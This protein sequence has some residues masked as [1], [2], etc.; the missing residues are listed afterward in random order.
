MHLNPARPE[1]RLVP[2]AATANGTLPT[3]HVLDVSSSWSRRGGMHRV[4]MARHERLRALGWRHTLMAPGAAGPGLIDCGGLSVPG[5]QGRLVLSRARASRQMSFI[6]PDLIEATDPDLLG[7]AALAAAR[8]LQV[9]AVAFCHRD[10][11]GLAAQRLGSRGAQRWARRYLVSLYER[12]DLVMAPSRH[13]VQ[14]LHAWG[15]PHA[16][17]QPL[18][19]DCS[20]FTPCARDAAWR[21]QFCREQGLAPDTRLIVCTGRFTAHKNLQMLADAVGLLGRGHALLAVGDGP[22]PPVGAH[23]RVLPHETDDARLARLVAACDAHVNAAGADSLGLGT[24][25]AMACGTPVVVAQGGGL[26]ELAEDAGLCVD[27]PRAGSW[28]EA[29]E[30]SLGQVNAA[31]RRTALAR[32]QSRDWAQVLTQWTRRYGA[33]LGRSPHASQALPARPFPLALPAALAR[34]R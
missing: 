15:L 26:A 21:E 12:F 22:A 33:L 7:W 16:T 28:A 13:L 32:A 23:V 25:E 10:L 31:Q 8:R 27:R 4:L 9:P 2:V 29:L 30:F 3:P 6:E 34:Q 19:V 5:L 1:P 18:G 14:R 20:I 11:P 17:L 24:L